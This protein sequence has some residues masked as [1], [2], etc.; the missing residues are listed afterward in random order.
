M[1]KLQNAEKRYCFSTR[2]E[3]PKN[4]WKQ[5]SSQSI[6][7]MSKGKA[8]GLQTSLLNVACLVLQH[9]LFVIGSGTDPAHCYFL[10][11]C[12]TGLEKYSPE[13]EPDRHCVFAPQT[14][15]LLLRLVI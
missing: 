4:N 9:A 8:A 7:G 14:T 2:I 5:I 10:H 11:L 6:N 12:P 3:I 1:H 15:E 13:F